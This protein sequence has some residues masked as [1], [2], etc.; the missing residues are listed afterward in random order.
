[1]P[2]L[3]LVALFLGFRELV[4]EKTD[5]F[6]IC[7]RHCAGTAAGN[8]GV[9]V[10][11]NGADYGKASGT[12]P[13]ARI[14]VYKALNQQGSGQSSDIIAAIDQAIKD[15]VHVLSLSLGGP[16]NPGKVTFTLGLEIAFLGAVKAGMFVVHAAGNLG[17]QIST[18]VSYSP[19][20]TSVGASS[21][22]RSYPNYLFTADGKKFSGQGLARK[23][24]NHRSPNCTLMRFAV[25]GR[26][27]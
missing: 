4:C 19:W 12:A 16:P 8:Q 7:C 10:V 25:M 18:V 6:Y 21:M 11:V 23:Q 14:S 3:I 20:I 13:R 26:S 2:R 22:D 5:E 1:M 17:S 15:G 24:T 27:V 9:S